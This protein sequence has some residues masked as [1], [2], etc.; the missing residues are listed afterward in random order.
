MWVAVLLFM[1]AFTAE[2]MIRNGPPVGATDLPETASQAQVQPAPTPSR[3]PAGN[4]VK[5][6]RRKHDD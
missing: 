1:G 2:E 3:Q 4:N 6:Q 5:T